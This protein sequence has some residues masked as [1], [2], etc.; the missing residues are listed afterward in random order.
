M[1]VSLELVR[2]R[3]EIPKCYVC[4]DHHGTET[5]DLIA[6]CLHLAHP[7]MF[8]SALLRILFMGSGRYTTSSCFRWSLIGSAEKNE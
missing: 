3:R 2:R 8:E 1:C 6:P 5:G 7:R 4:F